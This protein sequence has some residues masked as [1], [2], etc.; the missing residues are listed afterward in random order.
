M[1]Q[2]QLETISFKILKEYTETDLE[3]HKEESELSSFTHDLDPFLLKRIY[4]NKF[5]FRQRWKYNM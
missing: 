5:G 1:T 2:C 3:P 4:G